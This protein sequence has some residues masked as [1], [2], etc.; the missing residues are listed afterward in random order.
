[1]TNTTNPTDAARAKA[2][3]MKIEEMYK[4]YLEENFLVAPLEL[5]T[6]KKT[7]RGKVLCWFEPLLKGKDNPVLIEEYLGDSWTL[8][9][10]KKEA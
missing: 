2:V 6:D 9:F 10:E 8:R 4:W 1:M 3:N 7:Y 5:C